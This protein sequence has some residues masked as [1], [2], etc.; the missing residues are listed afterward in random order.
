MIDCHFLILVLLL[1]LS[2]FQSISFRCRGESKSK[3]VK[4][5]HE[6][7]IREKIE[8]NHSARS[9][10]QYTDQLW[11]GDSILIRR[12]TKGRTEGRRASYKEK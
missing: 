8:K 6:D 11:N 1:I 2:K 10:L 7:S 9:E 3:E 12:N 4:I 5:G